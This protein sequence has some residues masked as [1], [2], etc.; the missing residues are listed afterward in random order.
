MQPGDSWFQQNSK[1]VAWDWIKAD[2]LFWSIALHIVWAVNGPTVIFFFLLAKWGC[3]VNFIRWDDVIVQSRLHWGNLDNH[4]SKCFP[5]SFVM[6]YKHRNVHSLLHH[7]YEPT[8][9]DLRKPPLLPRF[10]FFLV[11]GW[12]A[13]DKGLVL[14]WD[15]CSEFM[16][17]L[18]SPSHQVRWQCYVRSLGK[19]QSVPPPAHTHL[20]LSYYPSQDLS[21]TLLFMRIISAKPAP[22]PNPILNPNTESTRLTQST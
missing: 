18:R 6:L 20:C 12:Q 17:L 15:W 13:E 19:R 3:L 9:V 1:L 2:Y 5:T 14:L 10:L 22:K 16:Y 8:L 4:H 7:W 21:L 11:S